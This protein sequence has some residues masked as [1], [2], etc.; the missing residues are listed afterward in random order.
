M[1][2][3]PVLIMAAV[4]AI[5]AVLVSF[6]TGLTGEQVGA[7]TALAAALLGI[8]VRSKVTPA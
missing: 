1:D 7:I 6:G 8:V 4:Q 5:L 3:E 2:R